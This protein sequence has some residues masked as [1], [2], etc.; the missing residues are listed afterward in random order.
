MYDESFP[1]RPW[2]RSTCRKAMLWG[3]GLIALFGGVAWAWRSPDEGVFGWAFAVLSGYG[4][5][6]WA[7]LL[8]IWWTAGRPAVVIE[9]TGIAY[10]PLHTFGP[11][12]V[13][14][15]KI[16]ACGPRPGTDSLRVVVEGLRRDRE[17]FLNLAVV[18]GQHSFKEKLEARL[19]AEGLERSDEGWERPEEAPSAATSPWRSP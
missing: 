7:T 12:R 15:R 11:K 14:F 9:E 10:Q 19:Q 1:F 13:P 18:Q 2:V 8:K 17:L 5:L 4:L 3:I 16:L 6:F